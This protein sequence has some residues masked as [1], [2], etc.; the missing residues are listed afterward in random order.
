MEELVLW[1]LEKDPGK[2]PQS[3]QVLLAKLQALSVEPW[4]AENQERWWQTHLPSYA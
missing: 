1:C 2:R 3:A 4:G